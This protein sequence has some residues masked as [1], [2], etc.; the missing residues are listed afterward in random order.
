M[1]A[2]EVF[3][4]EVGEGSGCRRPRSANMVHPLDPCKSVCLLANTH[5][6]A[7][8]HATL[9]HVGGCRLL[10]NRKKCRTARICVHLQY[11]VF[12]H[13]HSSLIDWPKRYSI[14]KEPHRPKLSA[15]SATSGGNARVA[16]TKQTNTPHLFPKREQRI[17]MRRAY[18]LV[19]LDVDRCKSDRNNPDYKYRSVST[20]SN[21]LQEI[22]ERYKLQHYGRRSYPY[23]FEGATL[24]KSLQHQWTRDGLRKTPSTDFDVFWEAGTESCNPDVVLMYKEAYDAFSLKEQSLQHEQIITEGRAVMGNTNSQPHQGGETINAPVDRVS[25]VQGDERQI[26]SDDRHGDD[27]NQAALAKRKV[28]VFDEPTSSTHKKKPAEHAELSVTRYGVQAD[29][30]PVHPR[31]LVWTDIKHELD[32]ISDLVRDSVLW[33]AKHLRLNKCQAVASPEPNDFLLPVYKRC[34]GDDWR[35]GADA[36]LVAGLRSVE[37]DTLALIA[38]F[39]LDRVFSRTGPWLNTTR[40]EY[41]GLSIAPVFWGGC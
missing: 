24:Y 19:L 15:D 25:D 33:L 29:M 9:V 12:F 30:L 7:N 34:W 17:Y 26:S 16:S 32:D 4:Q 23:D 35:S 27:S 40:G 36:L 3:D 28:R 18:H 39:L 22:C 21:A 11:P 14:M 5:R 38:A 8:L 13:D 1:S 10:V 41:T 37:D 6:L 20:R 31:E 2:K